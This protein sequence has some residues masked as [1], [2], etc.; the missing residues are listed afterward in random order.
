MIPMDVVGNSNM[1]PYEYHVAVYTGWN[2]GG[3]EFYFFLIKQILKYVKSLCHS[4]I[5]K[6]FENSKCMYQPLLNGFRK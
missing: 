1:D 2:A 6:T 5:F 3:G 4:F